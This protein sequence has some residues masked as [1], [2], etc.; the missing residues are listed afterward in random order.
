MHS[1][2][3]FWRY[4]HSVV[5]SASLNKHTLVVY[6]L[7][8]NFPASEFRRRGITQKKAYKIQKTAKVWI[9]E[10]ILL[11]TKRLNRS[12]HMH[13]YGA[14]MHGT[15]LIWKDWQPC[16][17]VKRA[18]TEEPCV[19]EFRH[20]LRVPPSWLSAMLCSQQ[21]TWQYDT[22]Q[23]ITWLQLHTGRVLLFLIILLV[24]LFTITIIIIIIITVPVLSLLPLPLLLDNASH[25]F[26]V[27]GSVHRSNIC[28]TRLNLAQLILS[29]NCSTCFG[30]YHHSS[31]GAQTTVS[32][33]SGICQTVTATWCDKYQML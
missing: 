15:V 20:T 10:K 28:S 26:N 8:G 5:E 3:P 27:H 2:F 19:S 13:W 31:S 9:E 11:H 25:V 7:L 32:T 29:G 23:Y 33:A 4:I 6:F 30:W 22:C 18:E 12:V 16:A 21:V 14:A 1:H 24:C 17:D